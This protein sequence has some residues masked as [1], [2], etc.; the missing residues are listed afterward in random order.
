M[1]R[2]GGSSGVRV[3]GGEHK[4]RTLRVPRGARPTEGRVREALFSI[5]GAELPGGRFLDLFAGSGAVAVEAAG[6]GALTVVAVE[7]DRRASHRLQGNVDHLGLGDLVEVRRGRLPELLGRWASEGRAQPGEGEAP[8]PFDLIFA[9]PPY[10][11]REYPE[12]LRAAATVLAEG[13]Q[14]AVEHS[15]RVELPVEL[16]AVGGTGGA[17]GEDPLPRPLVRADV[18]RYGECALS[19]Y[20]RLAGNLRPEL[21]G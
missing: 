17:R 13:G 8:G 1:S 21:D 6:R 11:F 19:F 9:D 15:A 3:T 5:W 16:P 4:G 7:A 20:R 14:I 10:D 18:R 12:L 2:R